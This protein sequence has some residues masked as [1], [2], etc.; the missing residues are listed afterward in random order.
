M[1]LVTGATG[2]NGRWVV[3]LLLRSG[4]AVRAMVQSTAK[5]TDLAQA[6]AQ[7]VAADF[8]NPETLRAALDGV[9]RCLLLSA[10]D[11]RLVERE[12]RFVEAAKKVGVRHLVKFSA[13]GAHP[14]ASFLFG[15]QHG[16]AEQLVMASGLPFTFLQPNFFMQKHLLVRGHDESP[17]R[18]LRHARQRAC[19]PRRRV[20]H[21]PRHCDHAYGTDRS[22]C[23]ESVSHHWT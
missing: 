8:D 17:W 12:G 14:A 15:R 21:R 13:I 6:G 11:Q 9:E 16:Q 20:R 18:V 22:S 3:R 4:A 23:G 1:I 5:A 2:T 7:V 10:V 19:E